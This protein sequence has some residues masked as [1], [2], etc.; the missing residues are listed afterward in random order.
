MFGQFLYHSNMPNCHLSSLDGNPTP[1]K[2]SQ[3]HLLI[4]SKK[5]DKRNGMILDF[6][7]PL[8]LKKH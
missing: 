3:I 1:K 5:K 7:H 4:F 8:L 2:Y 6:F